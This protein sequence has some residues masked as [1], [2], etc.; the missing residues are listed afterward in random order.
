MI[1]RKSPAK[2]S[3]LLLRVVVAVGATAAV[4]VAAC[5]GDVI[6]QNDQSGHDA[7]GPCTIDEPC[8][9][10]P[11]TCEDGGCGLVGRPEGVIDAGP[12]ENPCV[13][14]AGNPTCGIA[15]LIDGGEAPDASDNDV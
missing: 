1:Y 2:A 13:D 10:A 6:G 3:T 7:G 11:S 9:T 15:P 5:G 12:P 8:G 14:D 4:N